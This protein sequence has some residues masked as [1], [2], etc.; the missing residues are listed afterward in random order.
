MLGFVAETREAVAAVLRPGNA[1]ANTAIDKI[2]VVAEALR[3]LPAAAAARATAPDATEEQRIVVR[4]DTAGATHDLVEA[5]REMGLR[6]SIGFP[7][8]EPLR[9]TVLGL[10]SWRWLPAIEADGTLRDGA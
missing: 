8:V 10:E 6:Y 5:C 2:A 9:D 4:C 3:Q 7:I 1:G